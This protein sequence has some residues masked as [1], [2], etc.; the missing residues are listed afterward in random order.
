[1]QRNKIN[2]LAANYKLSCCLRPNVRSYGG[3]ED[4]F[5]CVTEIIL[6]CSFETET[7]LNRLITLYRAAKEEEKMLTQ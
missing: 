7:V 5:R 3:N 2:H 1:M 6:A 4:G